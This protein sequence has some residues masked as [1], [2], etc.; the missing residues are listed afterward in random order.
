[1]MK[2][3]RDAEGSA[4]NNYLKII[5]LISVLLLVAT[6]KIISSVEASIPGVSTT[7]KVGL[8][9]LSDDE[10]LLAYE[11][12]DEKKEPAYCKELVPILAEMNKRGSFDGPTARLS[13]HANMWCAIDEGRKL[14]AYQY[15]LKLES[16]AGANALGQ[17]G[18]SIAL[19]ANQ[20]EAAVDRLIFLAQDNKHDEL[21]IINEISIFDLSRSLL[22]SKKYDL[23]NEM[24][25][26]LYQ[27]KYFEQLTLNIQA[28]TAYALLLKDLEIGKIDRS[29][30]LL[31]KINSPASYIDL[32]ADRKFAPIWPVIEDAAGIN[33]KTIGAKF[34]N[35]HAEMYHK[36]PSNRNHFQEY[37]HALLYA[38]RF[39][40]VVELVKINDMTH[41]VEDDA[42][43]LNVKAY[44]LDSLGRNTEAESIFD[45][46][47][48]IPY[49]PDVNGWLV[50]FVINRAMRLVEV[51]NW[52]KGLDATILAE[53]I[54][55][56]SGNDYAN[57]LVQKTKVCV[58]T[59]IGREEEAKKILDLIFEKRKDSYSEAAKAMLCAND[60]NRAA[61]IVLE[62]LADADYYSVMVNDLQR[63]EFELFYTE[64]LLPTLN[65]KLRGRADITI[66]F[67]K[68]GRDIPELYIPEAGIR[69][70][71]FRGK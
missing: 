11:L 12:A 69:R 34:V 17:V 24:Y 67:N 8:A 47:A 49:D 9:L 64:S 55:K 41:L 27:S 39:E 38:G 62:A 25:E 4:R 46:I 18:F 70:K 58:L 51:G 53:V 7:P 5:G 40:D 44:A 35:Q 52:Q 68:V 31:A 28:D 21:L 20:D 10:L 2:T 26:A 66:A 59:R 33:L 54:V 48:A 43:A 23:R 3:K 60:E 29:K 57:M 63:P 13:A 30:A 36:D 71:E 50:S 16:F 19:Y 14:E 42:W 32:I 1:M 15:M 45:A 37:A 22:L 6:P 65:D 56:K 61:T